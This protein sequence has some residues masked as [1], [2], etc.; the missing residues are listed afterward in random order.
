MLISAN[1]IAKKSTNTIP[2]FFAHLKFGS[3]IVD[4]IIDEKVSFAPKGRKI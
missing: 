4:V 2:R 1:I 3:D